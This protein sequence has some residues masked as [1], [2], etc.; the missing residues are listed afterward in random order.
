[1]IT[2]DLG[3]PLAIGRTAEIYAWEG[4]QVLKLYFNWFEP[5][6]IQFEQH[7]AQAIH[8]SGLPVPAASSILQVN[9]RNG[10]LYERVDGQNMW[11]VFKKRP[12][13]VFSK[14]RLTAQLH[15]EMHANML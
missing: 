10:L 11:E 14:A 7:M 5:D 1:M 15:A 4:N 9:G 8:A 12:W 3:K 13:Q 2:L 6:N